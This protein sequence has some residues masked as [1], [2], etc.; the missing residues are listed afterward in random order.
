MANIKK[1]ITLAAVAFMLMLNSCGWIQGK[2]DDKEVQEL[3]DQMQ[4]F[5]N[6]TIMDEALINLGQMLA[7][8]DVSPTPIQSQN[9][10]NET[11]DKGV[12]SDLYVMVSTA[13]NKVGREVVFIPYD[14]QYVINEAT[15]GGTIQRIYPDAV[16]SGGITGVDKDLIQKERE[17]DISGG[18]AGASG[19][20]RYGAGMTA[21]KITLD[22]NM[23][24]YR[25][26][27][28]FPGVLA[29]NSILIR[30]DRLGWAVAASYMDFSVSFESEVKT[31][32]GVYAALRF[33]VE[34]STV[35][36][37]GKYFSV[38]YWKCIKGASADKTMVTRLKENIE[39]MPT[40]RQIRYIKKYLYLSGFTG[41]DRASENLSP[42][43]QAIFSSQMRL[44]AVNDYPSLFIAVWENLPM[45]KS[46]DIIA[47]D[48]KKQQREQKKQEAQ[49]REK[50]LEEQKANR[51]RQIEVQRQLELAKGKYES[52]ITQADKYYTAGDLS[53]AYNKYGEALACIPNDQYAT[54]QLNRTKALMESI[55]NMENAY[56]EA[57]VKGDEAY[58]SQ[59]YSAALEEYQKAQ[60]LK[61]TD[62]YSAGM[63][64]KVEKILND[65]N[66]TGIKNLSEDDWADGNY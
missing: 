9:I 52:A 16:V 31:K 41:M 2:V 10:G 63:V 19:S 22:L 28:F 3:D 24:N 44:Y 59:N 34:L 57:I 32:Q 15:T 58:N 47:K 11:A 53:N 46:L 64:I 61:T 35:E 33:L 40:G 65:K 26:Q 45:N 30:Q 38:P 54:D 17:G 18:W 25:T 62:L 42:S 1:Y 6:K 39:T 43:E 27:S 7:A 5:T 12:P 23:R 29:S 13:I 20:A 50:A 4:A 36:L 55:L 66:P 49:A 56:K 37:L 60:L 51:E 8:Y 14:T 48:R 21:S